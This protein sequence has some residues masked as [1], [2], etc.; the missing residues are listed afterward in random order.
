MYKVTTNHSNWISESFF[1]HSLNDK[2][3]QVREIHDLNNG[4][5]N[6][7]K[8]YLEE[9]GKVQI[10][11]LDKTGTITETNMKV[12]DLILVGSSSVPDTE[13]GENA[14]APQKEELSLA[15]GGL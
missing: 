9:T 5:S 7:L 11:A 13:S 2:S 1:S 12:H 4:K 8:L 14:P 10:V 15:V 3:L 6:I